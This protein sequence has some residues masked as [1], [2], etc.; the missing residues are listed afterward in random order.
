MIDC[1]MKFNWFHLDEDDETEGESVSENTVTQQSC[2]G[3]SNVALWNKNL[4][5][6][7]SETDPEEPN[8]KSKRS[9]R[10]DGNK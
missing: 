1:L 5:N 6:P 3:L 9:H 7:L 8:Y 4:Q 10:V 2:S